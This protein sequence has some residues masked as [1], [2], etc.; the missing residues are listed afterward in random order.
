MGGKSLSFSQVVRVIP[1]ATTQRLILMAQRRPMVRITNCD[2][3][4]TE[5]FRR[6]II[7]AF[8]NFATEKW[9]RRSFATASATEIRDVIFATEC[10][11]RRKL[12][13]NLRQ[14]FLRS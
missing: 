2:G 4:A 13:R 3:L 9:Y 8:S 5:I 11:V 6:K 7:D 10:V 12:R 1:E 14:T